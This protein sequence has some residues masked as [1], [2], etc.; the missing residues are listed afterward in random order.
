MMLQ[1]HLSQSLVILGIFSLG[2]CK[3]MGFRK[4]QNTPSASAIPSGE[5]SALEREEGISSTSPTEASV[6]P[7][8]A[9]SAVQQHAED[10]LSPYKQEAT[11]APQAKGKAL[12]NSG[13]KTLIIGDSMSEGKFGRALASAYSEGGGE[14][15]QFSYSSSKIDDWVSG[16][17]ATARDPVMRYSTNGS[18]PYVA[19]PQSPSWG[20]HGLLHNPRESGCRM[21]YFDRLVIQLGSN[22]SGNPWQNFESAL[23][24]ARGAGVPDIQFILPPGQKGNPNSFASYNKTFISKMQDLQ[25]KYKGLNISWINSSDPKILSLNDN[26]FV[27]KENDRTHLKDGGTGQSKWIAA[28]RKNLLSAEEEKVA[29]TDLASATTKHATP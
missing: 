14:S 26:E 23:A 19:A 1:K 25:Q 3:S 27:D 17:F 9:K 8:A 18:I 11:T 12:N 7:K 28:I 20:L 5:S 6:A 13:K 24:M 4:Q 29:E 22:P 2:S 10:K 21:D 15:C 16:D